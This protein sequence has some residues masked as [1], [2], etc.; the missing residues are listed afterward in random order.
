MRSI[1][2]TD[3]PTSRFSDTGGWIVGPT[4]PP[5]WADAVGNLWSAFFN[6]DTDAI[7]NTKTIQAELD[8]L[9]ALDAA[10]LWDRRNR[11]EIPA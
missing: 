2:E 10:G 4:E 11:V 3:E 1:P 9:Q 7:P 5:T 6:D 8:R